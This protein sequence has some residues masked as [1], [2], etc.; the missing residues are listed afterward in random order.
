[1]DF[2]IKK[3]K[4]NN[5]IF[6][7]FCLMFTSKTFA[8]VH[9]QTSAGI[10]VH[11]SS[12]ST[13]VDIFVNSQ[14]TQGLAGALV[15][16][17]A[18]NSIGEWNNRSNITLRKNV[19]TGSGQDQLNE[20]YFSSDQS[21][22][23][24]SSVLAVTNVLFLQA[25]GEIVNADIIVNATRFFS[26]DPMDEYY[27]G[28]V[29]THEAGHFLGLAHS[30]VSGSTMFYAAIKGQHE[31]SYDD[32][33]GIY[34]TY[35]TGDPAKG[36]IS[37]TMVGGKSLAKV[38]GAHVQALSVKTGKVMGSSISEIDGKF[39]IGGLPQNDQY[40]IYSSPVDPENLPDNYANVRSDFCEASKKYRGSF[41]QSCGA[42]T[43]GFPLAVKLNSSAVNAGSITI[44][45]GLDVPP[46]Y[47]Q[48]KNITPAQFNVNAYTPSGVG[49][50][51]VGY[52]SS[53]E[54]AAGTPDYFELDLSGVDWNTVST[55]PSL[56]LELKI[57][58][59]PF[60]SAFK[61]HVNVKYGAINYDVT[62]DY[63]READGWVNIDTF[64][65]IPINR[66]LSS[67]NVFEIKITPEDLPAG[68]P[69][70]KDDLFPA[71]STLQDSLYFYLVTASIV[72]DNGDGTYTQVAS[73][74]D[75]LSDNR[76]CP[77]AANTYALTNYSAR[78]IANSERDKGGGC[79]TVDMGED[80][81]GGGPG[82]FMVG[83]ILS[84]IISYASSRYSKM[85]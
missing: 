55:S 70:L 61:A 63:V 43:E 67:D 76:S 19:T 35:P 75:L 71:S 62:P 65:R 77:D 2:K 40:I 38:F 82:G 20:L 16:S 46:E 68:I 64:E 54:L 41:F 49:G 14:N 28:N 18:E 73:K 50:T 29:L 80:G 5:S 69:Y 84:F 39:S 36:T 4:L 7:L 44:R 48:T 85:V 81:K 52:F 12:R 10:A 53:A 11:W 8:Y 60:Y 59:Q 6:L 3:I 51:F 1:V 30:P 31:V 58:N 21:F 37:G 22:F 57:A 26:V 23:N 66:A 56:Y 42:S 27:L 83:L 24:G 13:T 74:N 33:A 78:G 34:D 25:S 72:K 9:S 45:C 15:Q 79:G 47:F 32:I 17:I